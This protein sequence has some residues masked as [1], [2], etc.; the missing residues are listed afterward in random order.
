MGAT[1]VARLRTLALQ[2]IAAAV[3]ALLIGGAAAA[4]G[5][6]LTEPTAAT[7]ELPTDGVTEDPT[8]EVTEDPTEEVTEDPTEE[9][10]EDPTEEVTEDPTEDVVEEPDGEGDG[11]AVSKAARGL[12]PPV[13]NC[14]NH[15]HWVSTVAKGL[16]SCDDNP[17][18]AKAQVDEPAKA[19]K[20]KD[21]PAHA[22]KP[23]HA[24][25]P[26]KAT[27]PGKSAGAKG[28][29]KRP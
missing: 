3:T 12:T 17:R 1:S 4:V 15:G 25:K 7:T 22:G 16:S 26:G 21:R 19:A 18:P 28:K 8:E 11:N 14:R 9:V 20:A 10:T 29:G 24:A 6:P 5:Q 27:A 23:A 13:G 2:G